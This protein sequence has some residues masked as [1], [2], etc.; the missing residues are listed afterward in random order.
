MKQGRGVDYIPAPLTSSNNGWHKDGSTC[1]TTPSTR[2]R[3]APAAPLRSRKGTG[4]TAPSRKSKR[5]CSSPTRPCWGVCE[6]PGSPWQR[7]S[8]SIMLEESCRFRD[9]RSTSVI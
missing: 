3:R 1:G 5:R 9:G 2:F 4:R 6:A 8:G 7:W